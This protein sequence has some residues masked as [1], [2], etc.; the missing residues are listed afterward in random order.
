MTKALVTGGAGFI[1][2]H[3]C[4]SLLSDGVAVVCFDNLGSGQRGNVNRFE[5]DDAYTFVEGD[6]REPLGQQLNELDTNFDYIYHFASRA[7][8]ADFKDHALEISQTNTI[9]TK[10]VLELAREMD[11]TVVYASTSEVYGDPKEHPQEES[12]RG[13]VSIR[14]PRA[15]YDEA[16]RFGETLCTMYTRQ[17][18]VDTRTVRI[19]NTYGPRMRSDDGRVV[20]TFCVQA[21]QGDDLTVYGEGDQTR[22]FLFVDDL[23]RGVR[24]F[25]EHD[26]LAGE[27]IN[28]GHTDETTINEFANTVTRLSPNSIETVY[29]PLPEDDPTRRRPDITKAKS[30]LDWEPTIDLETGLKK[31]LEYFGTEVVNAHP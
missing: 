12:Y 21:L 13:N 23:V 20:P 10:H 5:D 3:I 26:E 6:V 27:V 28:I 1:G 17:F 29:Q 25:A 31:T 16:K 9:G 11:A 7:S 14:G 2:T 18:G 8:P 22:S 30:L 19:F 15:P 4:D 24:T